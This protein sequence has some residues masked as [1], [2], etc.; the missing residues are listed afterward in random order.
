ML[1]EFDHRSIGQRLDLFHLQE[2]APGMV[3]WHPRGMRLFRLLEERVR[4]HVQREGYREVRTPQ[5]M[6]Q[7]IWE[8]SGHWQSFRE[9]MLLVGG[10]EGPGHAALKPVSCPAHIQLVRRQLP[11]FR[12]LPLRLA[13]FG[14]VHRNEASGAL[15]GLF[16]LRQFT[17][18]DGHI[19]CREE[20][21]A[22][23]VAR[24]CGSLRALY[25]DF[26]F[27]ELDV[28]FSSRPAVRAGDDALWDRAEAA[29]REAAEGAGLALR[30]Q[31]G[32]GAFYG[33]KL[34]FVLRDWQGRSWQCGTL[35]LDFVLPERFDLAYVDSGGA[36]RRPVMLHR[37]LLGSMERFLGVLLEQHRG[38]LPPWLCPEQVA[39]VGMG[40]QAG[41]YARELSARLEAAGLRVQVEPRAQSLARSIVEAYRAGIP[42]VAVV[43]GRELAHRR[44][45][46]RGRGEDPHDV[47]FEEAV[48]ELQEACRPLPG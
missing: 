1:D 38:A 26:G 20:Q 48:A 10:A 32:E 9:G 24:F 19:F 8:S 40:P 31:P 18:D 44:V 21:V 34:E 14:L 5:V 4:Q 11:S 25:A 23:E 42:Y 46:L 36:R 2:E 15:H 47:G 22:A 12:D 3:F 28:A 16:R 17:Q 30:H 35:Q 43:G 33:P 37:A 45:S 13:E 6:D 41:D 29:L 39:V 7:A 27:G